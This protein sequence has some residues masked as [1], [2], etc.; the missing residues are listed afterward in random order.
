MQEFRGSGPAQSKASGDW[1]HQHALQNTYVYL[2]L[3]LFSVAI[4]AD[5]V[6]YDSIYTN[7]QKFGFGKIFYVSERNWCLPRLHLFNQKY[8]KY[9]NIVKH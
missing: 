1:L 2:G 3:L 6:M 5:F 8:S 4:H 9:C 7:I